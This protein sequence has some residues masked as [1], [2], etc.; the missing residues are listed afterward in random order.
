MTIKGASVKLAADNQEDFICQ[1]IIVLNRRVKT[2][3]IIFYLIQ[4]HL[5]EIH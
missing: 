4:V 2:F 5:D 1:C 3:E